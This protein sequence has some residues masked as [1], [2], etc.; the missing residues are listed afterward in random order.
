MSANQQITFNRP[1][2]TSGTSQ[3]NYYN[4][5]PRHSAIINIPGLIVIEENNLLIVDTNNEGFFTDIARTAVFPADSTN[6]GF[7][8]A[9]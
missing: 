8:Q 7:F 4:Y 9:I 1:Y 3:D 6:E 5:L 2:D